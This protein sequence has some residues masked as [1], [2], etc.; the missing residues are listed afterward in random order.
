MSTKKTKTKI[1][2]Y[3]SIQLPLIILNS[4]VSL[5]LFISTIFLMTKNQIYLEGL[6]K[7]ANLPV[8]DVFNQMLDQQ[9]KSLLIYA[10]IGTIASVFIA[11]TLT[12]LLSAK[13]AEKAS[14]NAK[15][16]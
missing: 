10:G 6:L 4:S 3:P 16:E 7:Q 8:P 13:F 9:L 11:A 2:I 1:L 15:K 5:I 12:L 14:I